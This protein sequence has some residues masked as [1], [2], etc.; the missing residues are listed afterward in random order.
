MA[1]VTLPA[2][3]RFDELVEGALERV[4]SPLADRVFWGASSACDH[5][6]LWHTVGALRA[7]RRGSLGDAVRFSSAM[8]FESFVTNVAVKSLF[9]RPRPPGSE[10]PLPA[11]LHRPIT[12]SFPSGHATA[13]FCA[14]SLLVRDGRSRVAW[15]GLAAIVGLSRVYVRLHH[16][17][18][19]VAGAVLGRVL[20]AAIAPVVPRRPVV[21]R[22]S[23]RP[24]PD[25][26]R[27]R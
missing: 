15:Y 10:E 27:H 20:G 22:W 4:R 5:G 24:R 3:T 7:V 25:A 12:S 19:V 1:P 21:R 17:S 14:A 18:D 2:V 8:G 9:Q 16:P 23:T 6:L 13:A 26:R 11:D